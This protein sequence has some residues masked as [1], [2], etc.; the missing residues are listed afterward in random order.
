MAVSQ[1][2]LKTDTDQHHGDDERN[3]SV[4]PTGKPNALTDRQL[5]GRHP[6]VV[7]I[8]TLAGQGVDGHRKACCILSQSSVEARGEHSSE[9]REHQTRE[10]SFCQA[11]HTSHPHQSVHRRQACLRHEH[12]DQGPHNIQQGSNLKGPPA[13]A[14]SVCVVEAADCPEDG[15]GKGMSAHDAKPCPRCR[16]VRA[17]QKGSGDEEEDDDEEP[18]QA[19]EGVR[20]RTVPGVPVFCRLE[21]GPLIVN[22]TK[23][24]GRC[25]GEG[26]LTAACGGTLA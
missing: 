2:T 26:D 22:C 4:L 24:K 11:L 13:S 25:D 7:E 18:I 1:V 8:Q 19:H 16:K 14:S 5:V 15:C 6:Q 3:V 23:Q 10:P 9:S 21:A 17:L 12:E 20:E